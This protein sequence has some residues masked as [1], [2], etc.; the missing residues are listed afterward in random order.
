MK[1]LTATIVGRVVRGRA[2]YGYEQGFRAGRADREDHRRSNSRDCYAYQD[3][4][5]GY[6]GFYVE[7]DD[8]NYYFR[9]GFRRGYEDGYGSRHRYGVISNGKPGHP[10]RSDGRNHHL[11]AD[12]LRGWCRRAH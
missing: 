12:P 7:R 4:N 2:N 8:Y 1:L 3:A 5:H 11:R 6:R 10:R 9:E